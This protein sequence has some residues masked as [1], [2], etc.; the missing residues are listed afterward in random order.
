MREPLKRRMMNTERGKPLHALVQQRHRALADSQHPVLIRGETGSGKERTARLMHELNPNRRGETFVALN[1][2]ALAPGTAHSALFGHVRGA[3]TGA[4][5]SRAGAFKRAD[6]GTLFLDEVADLSFEMQGALLRALDN[7]MVL[8]LGSDRPVDVDVRIVS[9]THKDLLREVQAH[10]FRPDL[11]YRL[12]VLIVDVLPL[13]ERPSEIPGLAQELL[14]EV[15]AGPLR[16]DALK[17]LVAHSWPGNVRELRN[18]LLRAAVVAGAGAPV[19]VEHL[20]FDSVRGDSPQTLQELEPLQL[21]GLTDALRATGGNR[22]RAAKL[23]GI[24]RSTL[25]ARLGRIDID[26]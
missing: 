22:S 19:G 8:P 2:A 21:Q 15:G 20:M 3:F 10:R 6:R 1:C 9:A 7:D 16:P 4:S 5:C 14:D 25:Y 26:A 18:V 24:S 12:A 11:Y 17:G 13:R 23:L